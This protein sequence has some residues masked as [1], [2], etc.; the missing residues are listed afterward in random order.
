MPAQPAEPRHPRILI[1]GAVGNLG[2]L[3]AR[4]LLTQPAQLR[5]MIH[6]TPP[7]ART[8]HP[9]SHRHRRG[10]PSRPRPPA[11]APRRRPRRR[12]HRPLRRRPLRPRPE[13][14][15]PTTNTRWFSNLL[16]AALHAGVRRVILISFPHTEGPTTPDHPATGRLDRTPISAHARTRL[17]EERLLLRRTQGT[18]TEPV[19]LRLGMVYGRGILMVEAARWLAKRRLLGVWRHPTGI[20]LISTADYLTATAAAAL[21]PNIRGIYHLGDDSPSPSSTSSTAPATP[22]AS[23]TPGA[24]PSGSSNSPP[25]SPNSAPPSS[26]NPP[27]SP[28]T[29]STS[30]ASPT[31]ATPPRA[32]TDLIPTLRY[33]TLE[34]GLPTLR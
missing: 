21:R 33:P 27:P 26:A 13:R 23:A 20:H 2:S 34:Q 14:F 24:C 3:L 1:T 11:L 30:D 7:P 15:L 4:H 5:L 29:S 19:I 31:T 25:P 12:R 10:H 16:E 8:R 28:A 18:A 9:R 17:E 6:R 32:R 22:G